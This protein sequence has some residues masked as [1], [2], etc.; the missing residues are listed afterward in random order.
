M[1]KKVVNFITYAMVYHLNHLE[2]GFENRSKSSFS[3]HIGTFR[4]FK[5]K[6]KSCKICEKCEHEEVAIFQYQC[7]GISF[8]QFRQKFEKLEVQSIVLKKRE[9]RVS[10]DGKFN[11]VIRQVHPCVQET[12][13]RCSKS[14][15]AIQSH[16]HEQCKLISPGSS[17]LCIFTMRKSIM[18]ISSF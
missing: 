3:C 18:Q 10:Y 9:V 8:A 15:R 6:F 14:R 17:L 13:S 2:K 4:I 11:P 16:L 5:I 1:K 12:S 7:S